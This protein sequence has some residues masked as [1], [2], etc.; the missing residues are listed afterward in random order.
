MQ[1]LFFIYCCGDFLLQWVDTSAGDWQNYNVHG[2]STANHE[3]SSQLSFIGSVGVGGGQGNSD[4]IYNSCDDHSQFGVSGAGPYGPGNGGDIGN[5][6][7]PATQHG[8][9]H[10]LVAKELAV[11]A[12]SA[13]TSDAKPAIARPSLGHYYLCGPALIIGAFNATAELGT[14]KD[15]SSWA[16]RVRHH[17]TAAAGAVSPLGEHIL[18][19]VLPAP[20]QQAA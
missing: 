17:A 1:Q 12:A 13:V 15:I 3:G 11:P 8:A 9:S 19:G 7:N 14:G 16:E 18:E 20:A 10:G 5:L 2:V 4:C 6:W